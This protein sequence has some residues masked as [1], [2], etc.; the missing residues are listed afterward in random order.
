M[1]RHGMFLFLIAAS[2]QG[3]FTDYRDQWPGRR[4]KITPADLPPPHATPGAYNGP[5][6]IPRP[7]G[8]APKAPPDFKVGLYAEGLDNPRQTRAAPNGDLFVAE[9]R[10]GMIKVFRGVDEKGRARQAEVFARGLDEP[11]GIAFYPPGK[12]P[13]YVYVANT[14]SVVRFPYKSGD[15]KAS[16]EPETIVPELPSGGHLFGGG[17]WTRDVVFSLD[18]KTMFVSVGSRSN[19]DDVDDNPAEKN[20]ADVLAAAPDGSGLHVYASGLRNAV[21]LAVHP[22]TGELWASV[23][24]RDMLGDDLPPDFITHVEKGGFYGWPW[25]YIGGHPDPRHH[26]KHPELKDKVLVP[27]VLVEPHNASL[28]LTVYE[29]GSFPA[30]Y[31]GD[32]FAAEHGSW[33]RARRTGYEVIRVPL[34]N[35]RSDGGYEDFVTGFVT[36]EGDVW[37]RPVGVAVGADGA[38]YVTDDGSGSIW[39]VSYE[40]K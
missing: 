38:L 3:P 34:K 22:K 12:A 10:Q 33:N 11:F 37:G 36:P 6:L 19:N 30:A 40:G 23:N 8:A 24:E 35:G 5:R 28:G 14:G 17:H 1:I 27:D 4:H 20:R 18:G 13:R 9:S 32:I 15:M 29:G 31:R 26:G 21:G 16:G 25:Y 39:R 2:A 7:P